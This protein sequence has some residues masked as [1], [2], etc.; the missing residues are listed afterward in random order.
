MLRGNWTEST[1]LQGSAKGAMVF[2][3]VLINIHAFMSSFIKYSLSAYCVS[4]PVLGPG[5]II[6][7][8]KNRH[9]FCSREAYSNG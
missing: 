6:V 4:A 9:R 5:V 8:G 3:G 2:Q 7:K 1:T